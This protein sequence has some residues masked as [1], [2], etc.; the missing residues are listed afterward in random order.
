MV[1]LIQKGLQL[2]HKDSAPYLP[3]NWFLPSFLLVA[4]M[5]LS[6]RV[7]G[8]QWEDHNPVGGELMFLWTP[9]VKATAVYETQL[10]GE[11]GNAAAFPLTVQC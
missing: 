9:V 6:S 11:R 4:S 1:L 2:L 10:G 7:S 5:P 3:K 8:A